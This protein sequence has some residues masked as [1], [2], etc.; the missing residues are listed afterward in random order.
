MS[1]G[2]R[3][4][5]I[6]RQVE[7]RHFI[8]QNPHFVKSALSKYG[9]DEF[10]DLVNRHGIAYHEREHGQLFCDDS[11]KDILD[12]LLNQCQDFGVGI[13]L[14]TVIDSIRATDD[15]SFVLQT[16]HKRMAPPPLI[17]VSIWWLP[18]AVYP[19]RHLGRV[20][21]AIKWQA[22]LGIASSRP[23]LP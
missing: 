8:S 18:Q 1:G 3:C 20:A 5:F 21:L 2:G 22:S 14:H 13:H 17:T 15:D 12:M 11:A 9:S 16:T 4:N 7:P 6:N 23:K 10:I 19:F